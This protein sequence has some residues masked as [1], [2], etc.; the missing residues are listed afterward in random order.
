MFLLMD[1]IPHL[2]YF[3]SL[4]QRALTE[5]WSEGSSRDLLPVTCKDESLPSKYILRLRVLTLASLTPVNDILTGYIFSCLLGGQYLVIFPFHY[6]ML[7][8]VILSSYHRNILI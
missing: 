4:C 6:F 3:Q 1:I 5:R 2:T 8:S 7:C